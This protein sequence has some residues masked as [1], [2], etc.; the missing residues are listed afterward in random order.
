M[1][2]HGLEGVTGI[3]HSLGAV[4]SWWASIENPSLFSKLILIDPVIM[5]FRRILMSRILP[6]SLR[7]KYIPIVRIALRR[8]D[9]WESRETMSEHLRSK[10]VFQRFDDDAFQDFVKYGVSDSENG[11][12]LRFPKAWE[13]R[14]YATPPNMWPYLKRTKVP[15]A[16]IKAEYSDV[17]TAGTWMR[18]KKCV[19]NAALLE[20]PSVGHLYPFEKPDELSEWVIQNLSS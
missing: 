1:T 8:R 4:A 2:K 14:I 11:V 13:A 5:N 12:T 9:S 15:L 7:R 16:I 20:V 10:R 19:P 18:I 17:I 3:G 6:H